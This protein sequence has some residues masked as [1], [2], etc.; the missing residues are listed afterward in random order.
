MVMLN[1]TKLVSLWQQPHEKVKYKF[2]NC[3]T[4]PIDVTSKRV[5]LDTTP[6]PEL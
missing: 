1:H 6:R 2:A 4:H 3:I 5:T